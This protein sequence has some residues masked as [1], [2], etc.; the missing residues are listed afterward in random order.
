MGILELVLAL[1][2]VVLLGAG[3][4]GAS[5]TLVKAGY[6]GWWALLLLFPIANLIAIAVLGGADWPVLKRLRALEGAAGRAATPGAF[7]RG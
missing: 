5:R 4:F 3:L 6:S 1:V 2:L 7:R